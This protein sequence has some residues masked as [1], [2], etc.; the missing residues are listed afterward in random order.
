MHKMQMFTLDRHSSTTY[1]VK[2]FAT[3]DPVGPNQ[4]EM[5]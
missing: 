4:T 5:V 3:I 1:Q 2:A